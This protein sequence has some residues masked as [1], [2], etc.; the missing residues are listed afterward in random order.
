[1]SIPVSYPPHAGQPVVQGVIA[2]RCFAIIID[3]IF[4]AIFGLGS[5]FLITVF[6][7]L[8]FGFGWAAFHILPWFPLIYYILFI[9]ASGATPGQRMCGLT[10]RQS[11][12]LSS[13]SFAQACVWSLFLWLSLA[14]SGLPFLLAFFN[15]RR[16]AAHDLLS[17][18]V[19]LRAA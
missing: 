1:M 19:I 4:M 18:L 14:L 2:R 9:T 3:F 17:G 5:V 7:L 13:P 11:D 8:T 16:R 6:G 10:M 12:N 15:P